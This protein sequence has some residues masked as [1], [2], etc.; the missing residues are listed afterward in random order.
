MYMFCSWTY[1]ITFKARPMAVGITVFSRCVIVC[2]FSYEKGYGNARE[3]NAVGDMT[4]AGKW[5]IIL[6]GALSEKKKK[7]HICLCFSFNLLFSKNI[8]SHKD[9][10]FVPP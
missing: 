9:L 6:F 2:V 8:C 4:H 5:L 7:G 10:C 3:E 1:G